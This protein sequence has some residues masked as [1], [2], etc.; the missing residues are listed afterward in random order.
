MLVEEE[1]VA[2]ASAEEEVAVE[3]VAEE[4]EEDG[5]DWAKLGVAKEMRA[6]RAKRGMHRR[7]RMC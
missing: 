1:V 4:L 6:S 7:R 2:E 3:E 5:D